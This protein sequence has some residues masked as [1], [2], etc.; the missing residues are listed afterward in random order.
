[1]ATVGADHEIGANLLVLAVDGRA[2]ADGPA[3]FVDQALPFR[4]HQQREARESAAVARHE[5]EEVPLRHHGD[6]GRR[7]R[8]MREVGD[9]DL[10]V[11]EEAGEARQLVMRQPQEF[12]EQAELVHHRERRGMDGVAAEI[13]QEVAVLLQHHDR[14]AR[15]RQQEAQHHARGP[16]AHDAAPCAD[17]SSISRS[18]RPVAVMA[19][20]AGTPS[21]GF[22]CCLVAGV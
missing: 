12:L 19:S 11:A 5:I 20:S 10:L 22:T 21:A 6:V 15:P 13:T 4:V 17:H 18:T 8:Q 16:A 9:L 3:A 1:M 14:H 7:Y 2:H